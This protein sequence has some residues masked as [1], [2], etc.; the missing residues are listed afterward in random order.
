MVV[1]DIE[2]HTISFLDGPAKD[3][4]PTIEKLQN[5]IEIRYDGTIS[6]KLGYF[7]TDLMIER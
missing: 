3:L 1:F 6:Q 7:M 5:Y 2:D 4:F